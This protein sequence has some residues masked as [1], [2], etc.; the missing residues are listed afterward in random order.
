MHMI[1]ILSIAIS[2]SMDAFSLSLAYGTLPMGKKDRFFLAFIV[3]L[4]HFFMPLLGL[5]LGQFLIQTLH[6]D[7]N[8]VIFLVFL[9]IGIQMILESRKREDV[10]KNMN[11]ME[12]L[13]FGFAVSL[14]SFSVGLGLNAITNKIF[15]VPILFSIISFLFTY[16]GL[17]LGNRIKEIFGKISTFVGGVFLIIIGICYLIK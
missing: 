14:D 10:V 13:V 11:F 1:L 16:L 8:V 15:M 9:F 4:Y 6:L 3:G 17:F 5:W 12:N 2:L 7:P